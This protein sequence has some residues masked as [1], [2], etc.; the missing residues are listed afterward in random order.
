MALFGGEREGV[1]EGNECTL[2]DGFAYCA[3]VCTLLTGLR[4]PQ[5]VA[6]RRAERTQQ[7]ERG[8]SRAAQAVGAGGVRRATGRAE[9]PSGQLRAHVVAH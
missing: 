9:A 7:K 6:Q 3:P 8:G 5:K 1:T 2:R 4:L